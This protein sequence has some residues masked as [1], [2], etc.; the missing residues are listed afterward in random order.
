MSTGAMTASLGGNGRTGSY[1]PLRDLKPLPLEWRSLPRAFVHRARASWSQAALADSSGTT[2]TFGN[3]L[4][5]A[6]VL[7]RVLAREWGPAE[8]VGLMVPPTV[9][10]AV[11]NLAASL[12]GK[13][14]VNLNYS[15][16]QSLVDA[17]IAQCGITHVVTSRRLLDKVGITPAGKLILLEDIPGRVRTTDKLWGAAVAKV[18][19]VGA[20]SL[21]VPGLRHDHLDGRATVIFTSGSTGDPKGVVLSHRNILSNVAQIEQ[22]VQL[23][24]EEVVLGILPFFHSFGFTV[25]IWTALCLGKKV[26]YHV[27]PLDARTIGKLCEEHKVT[28]LIGT[29]TFSRLYLKSCEPRQFQTITHWIVGAEKLKPEL[30]S[31]IQ[32]DLGIEPMEGYGCTELSPVVAVNVP[33][34]V[35]QPDGRKIHGNRLGTVG[36]PMPDTSIKT[37]NPDTGADL[38]PGTEGVIA[39]KGPQV[40]VGYLNRPEATA[41]V[42]KDG[43]YLTGDLG[44]V[45]GDGFIKITDRLSRFSKIAGEM[46]PHLSIESAIVAATGVDE[47]QVAVTGVPDPKH[48]ERLIVLYT[49]LGISPS[50]VQHRLTAGPLPKVWIPSPRDFVHVDEIP[51]TPTGKVDLRRLK[52][53]ALT[54]G[55]GEGI[56]QKA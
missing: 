56:S 27:N 26:V 43:W 12:W 8:H 42:I 40:M 49:D 47:N 24:P 51:I 36:Q 20:M 13:V 44:Y 39:V 11:A 30:A 14:P 3:A 50:E 31:E 46:V 17:S 22:H 18:M 21:F 16:S 33:R 52:Q 23:L 48:G 2:L 55:A 38:P 7:G 9:P 41:Q 54:Q 5:R 34:E 4:L 1:A 10:A 53:I 29:P 32:R 15:A 6:L 28:L 37:V 19:P 45:D 35:E 25:T